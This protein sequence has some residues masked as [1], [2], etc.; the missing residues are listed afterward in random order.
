MK[1]V[2]ARLCCYVRPVIVCNR[3]T[4]RL[5]Q[6]CFD[7]IVCGPPTDM[8]MYKNKSRQSILGIHNKESKNCRYPLLDE[9]E[10]K[11]H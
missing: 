2:R 9:Y 5:C 8:K 10:Y 4:W 7:G 1:K 3:C 11:Y 6:E